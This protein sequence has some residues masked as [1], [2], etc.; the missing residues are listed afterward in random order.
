MASWYTDSGYRLPEDYDRWN[1]VVA[2]LWT[3]KPPAPTV[4]EVKCARIPPDV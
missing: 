2:S 1:C 4:G 3:E